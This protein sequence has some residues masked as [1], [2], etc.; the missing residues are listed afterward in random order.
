[1]PCIIALD[2]ES[3]DLLNEHTDDPFQQPGITEIG[4]V[5][6]YDSLQTA[7][8]S[9]LIQPETE[10]SKE[11]QE[12]TG[13]SEDEVKDAPTLRGAFRE[14]ANFFIGATHLVT[15]NG[16]AFD[17]P[18]LSYNLTRYNLQYKFPWPPNHIDM[19]EVGKDYMKI[20]GKQGIKPPKLM[21]LYEHLFNMKFDDHH[22]ALEDAEATL[23]CY[24]YLCSK[25]VIHDPLGV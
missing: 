23:D 6:L 20:K 3:T 18:L 4:A 24:R 21:E 12:I 11:A 14:F 8:Y 16:P 25:K 19:M 10:Y 22:R 7:I 1:M 17:I 5:K 2:F 15:F 9:Q 13:I